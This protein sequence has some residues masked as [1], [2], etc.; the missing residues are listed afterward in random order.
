MAIY[1]TSFD[2][3]NTAIRAFLTRVVEYYLGRSF[4]TGDGK[5]KAEK[6]FKNVQIESVK[7][8]DLYR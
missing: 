2:A 6:L 4:N 3:A 5:A 1:N 8:L 7:S